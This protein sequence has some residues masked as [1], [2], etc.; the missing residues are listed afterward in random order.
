MSLLMNE[1]KTTPAN[2][3]ESW[4]D[5]PYYHLLYA[6]RDYSEAEFFIGNLVT[7]L[8]LKAGAAVLDL[9]CG[10][11]RHAFSLSGYDLDVLGLD[12]SPNSIGEARKLTHDS[13]HFDVHDM[14]EVYPGHQFDVVF[15]LFTSFGY[16]DDSGENLKVLK[17]VHAML[18]PGGKLIIDFMNAAKTIR[19][20]VEQEVKTVEG[21]DFH[22]E[23]VYDGK[24]IFKHIRFSDKGTDFHFTERVQAL[25]L[26][27]FK[28]LL[29]E[30]G[31]ELS[32]TY[33]NYALD[34]FDSSASPRLI[35]E[36]QKR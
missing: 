2:W 31:F 4:F 20:L 6:N 21:V 35:L 10:K 30:A 8:K 36:A 15:N 32:H 34:P 13:L 22:I 26:N 7:K 14:R 29:E 12:L 3:F 11:G 25:Q 28:S 27:D 5:S 23:R 18:L 9:A 1:N 24:H 33:G 19:E 16:F 17:S